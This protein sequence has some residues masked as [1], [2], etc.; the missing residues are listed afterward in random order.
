MKIGKDSLPTGIA[1]VPPDAF[2]PTG[3]LWGN[4]V[5]DWEVLREEN[6]SWWIKRI[7]RELE[8]TDMLRIDHFRGFEAY[9]EVPYGDATAEGGWL[10]P[11]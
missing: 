7:E 6:Y 1:G 9:W 2:S 11:R 4:P 5:Y 3:Q 10:K 8:L